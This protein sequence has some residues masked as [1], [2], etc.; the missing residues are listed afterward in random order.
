[1]LDSPL[2]SERVRPG[3]GYD[4]EAQQHRTRLR[5]LAGICSS[6]SANC[7]FGCLL[8]PSLLDDA[9]RRFHAS[10]VASTDMDAK[11]TLIPARLRGVKHICLCLEVLDDD[12]REALSLT[13]DNVTICTVANRLTEPKL[14]HMNAGS[15]WFA[16]FLI[17]GPL[18]V[19]NLRRDRRKLCRLQERST[20]NRSHCFL[21]MVSSIFRTRSKKGL[22]SCPS[23]NSRSVDRHAVGFL[24]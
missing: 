21:Q 10:F 20:V 14:A 23:M 24:R 11:S 22:R 17:E 1:M 2:L 8:V 5:D 4:Q 9:A 7:S 3:H 12:G 16:L 13:I 6:H 15:S 19:G 18:C